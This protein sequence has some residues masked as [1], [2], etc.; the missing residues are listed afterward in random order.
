MSVHLT[1]PGEVRFLIAAI[2]DATH[3][4]LVLKDEA[5]TVV[6]EAPHDRVAAVLLEGNGAC[7]R[8]KKILQNYKSDT[9][10]RDRVRLNIHAVLLQN[11]VFAVRAYHAAQRDYK[12]EIETQT[13]RRV[14]IVD[15]SADVRG[16]GT[17][18]EYVRNAM[19]E[20]SSATATATAASTYL[21]AA[22]RYRDVLR[23]EKSIEEMHRMFLDL[24]ILVDAQGDVL[25]VVE[26]QVFTAKDFV[27][28]GN[29]ELQ[30]AH[31]ARK[32]T[33]RR[34]CC[35]VALGLIVLMIVLVPIVA[36]L[37]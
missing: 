28:K 11:F 10:E 14:R 13:A 3:K 27:A 7:V 37:G 18:N 36:T 9:D 29:T 22:D 32:A 19:L 2:K 1:Q 17:A 5:A 26:R 35:C 6:G 25:D 20:Q 12:I 16:G 33:R 24:A 34:M 31:K 23:L 21:D 4:I 8:C 15:P 30:E